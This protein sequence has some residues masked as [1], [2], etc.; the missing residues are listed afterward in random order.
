MIDPSKLQHDYD[1]NEVYSIKHGVCG[2]EFDTTDEIVNRYEFDPP[3]P[4]C[5]V[6]D[7]V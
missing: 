3:C 5:A 7:D 2:H 1:A 4:V 6:G